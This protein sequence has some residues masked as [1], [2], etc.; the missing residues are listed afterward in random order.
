MESEKH[1]VADIYQDTIQTSGWEK[2][3]RVAMDYK[4][5]LKQKYR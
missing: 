3:M 4:K 2:E 5:L 1:V